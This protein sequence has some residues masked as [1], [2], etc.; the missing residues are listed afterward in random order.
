[1]GQLGVHPALGASCTPKPQS[2][3]ICT[4]GPWSPGCCFLPPEA[5]V[6]LSNLGTGCSMEFNH[7]SLQSWSQCDRGGNQIIWQITEQG[8]CGVPVTL[9]SHEINFVMS[10]CRKVLL[11]HLIQQKRGWYEITLWM[12]GMIWSEQAGPVLDQ[13]FYPLR[14]Y[15]F[16]SSSVKFKAR[17]TVLSSHKL[18]NLSLI[19]V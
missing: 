18:Q 4:A 3:F 13:R 11:R 16:W 6:C 9:V 12:L 15:W 10:P 19:E 17:F 2:E 8:I 5:S 14:L 7:P 1:M